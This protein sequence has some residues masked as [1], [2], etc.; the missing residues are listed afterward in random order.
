MTP[1]PPLATITFLLTIE[2]TPIAGAP[3]RIDTETQKTDSDGKITKALSIDQHH[4]VETGLEAIAFEPLYETGASLAA[5]NPV[6]LPAT[7]LVSSDKAPCRVLVGGEPNIYFGTTNSTDHALSVPL[8]YTELNAIYSVTG[9]AT[10]AETF[11]PGASGFIV[12]ENHFETPTGLYGVWKFLGQNVTVPAIPDMCADTGVPGACQR[13]SDRQLLS[14]FNYARRAIVRMIREAN[15]AAR[16][17]RWRPDGTRRTSR[18]I[19][20]RGAHVLVKMRRLLVARSGDKFV[21]E[22]TPMSCSLIRVSKSEVIK[23][24]STLYDLRFPRGLEHL[25]KRKAQE[26]KGLRA[27]LRGVP[28]SYVVCE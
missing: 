20:T 8:E 4:S 6:K 24:F 28:D 1:T 18:M 23:T 12:R 17:G 15:T 2:E 7:R 21:C 10:P 5:R 9:G 25:G 3:I 22:L 14:P 13:I 19:Y 26:V 27:V 11:A 16:L